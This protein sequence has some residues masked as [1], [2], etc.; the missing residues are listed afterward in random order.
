MNESCSDENAGTKVAH[1]KE[2]TAWD[3]QAR[4]LGGQNR[5]RTAQRRHKQDDEES[6]DV[7]RKV[8]FFLVNA[9][10][11]ASVSLAEGREVVDNQ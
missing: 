4:E 5:K 10:L 9:S 11:G 3:S 6:S 1:G 2:E 8:V 7:K